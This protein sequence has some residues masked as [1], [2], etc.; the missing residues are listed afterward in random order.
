MEN[1]IRDI[2]LSINKPFKISELLEKTKE[3]NIDD[4]DLVLEVLGELY[5]IGKV[6]LNNDNNY[7]VV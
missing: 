4:E 2:V 7:V 1:I 6:K 3:N 5:D